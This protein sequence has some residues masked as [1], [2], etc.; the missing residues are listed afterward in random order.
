MRQLLIYTAAYTAITAVFMGMG[1]WDRYGLYARL[2]EEDGPVEWVSALLMLATCVLVVGLAARLFKTAHRNVLAACGLLLFAVL[3]FFALLE[4]VSYGQRL[5]GWE[6]SQFFTEHSDQKETNIHNV[7]QA[8]LKK[9]GSPV[10]LTRQFLAIGVGLYGLV[11]PVMLWVT[12]RRP[13]RGGA[14]DLLVPPLYLVSGFALGCFF[15]WAD[16]PSGYEEEIGEMFLASCL[17]IM[18]IRAL[19]YPSEPSAGTHRGGVQTVTP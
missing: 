7:V 13:A 2:L 3:I 5:F 11:L 1:L 6:S 4:E 8:Y 10:Y 19:R 15:L 9:I 12:G 17:L 18:T 16:W 14:A